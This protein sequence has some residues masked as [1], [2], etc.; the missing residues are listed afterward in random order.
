MSGD[1]TRADRT[2]PVVRVVAAALFDTMGRVLIT[3]RPAGRHMAGWWEFPG[4]KVGAGESDAAALVRELCEELGIEAQPGGELLTTSHDY[5][6]RTV[7]LVLWRVARF[8]G[9]PRGLEGQRLKWVTL[10]GLADECLLEADRPLIAALRG[11]RV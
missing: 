1:A 6:D 10:E 8:T 2:T 5:P 4:G 3:E 11:M 7:Q 9:E